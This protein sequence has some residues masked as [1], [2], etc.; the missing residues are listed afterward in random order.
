MLGIGAALS[1]RRGDDFPFVNFFPVVGALG[2]AI[3]ILGLI[4]IWHQYIF[5]AL[6][7]IFAAAL[8][9]SAANYSLPGRVAGFISK[10]PLFSAAFALGLV[11]FS[12]AALSYPVSTDALYFHLGLPKIYAQSGHMFFHPGILFSAGPRT[13]E[14]ISTGFY[15]LG[16]ERGA[17]FFIIL[18]AAI[19]LFAVYSRAGTFCGHGIWAA[20]LLLSV[21]IFVTQLTGSKNDYLLWGLCFFAALK[22]LEFRETR[23]AQALIL[24][25]AAAGMAAGTKAIGLAMFGPPAILILIEIAFGKNRLRHLAYFLVPSVLLAAPW[26]AYSWIVTGNPVFPF[27]DGLF[28]SHETTPLF[29]RFNAYLAVPQIPRT[30]L[31]FIISPIRL[32][33]QPELYDGRLGY[34]LILF[35]ALLIFVARIPS[36]IKISLGISL[37]FYIIWFFG[38][39][40]ARFLLPVGPLLAIAGSYFISSTGMK[41]KTLWLVAVVSLVLALLAPLPG[42]IRDTAPR[43]L[44][45]I[46]NTPRIEYLR[47]FEALDPYQTQSGRTFKPIAYIDC[48]QFINDHTPPGSKIGILTSFQTRADAFYLDR[49]FYYLNPSEQVHF[50][51]T[52]LRGDEDIKA[53]LSELGITH[54]VIDSAVIAEYSPGSAWSDKTGFAVFAGG[55]R[56]LR[57]YGAKSGEQIYRDIRFLVYEL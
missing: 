9:W 10:H 50:D 19:L 39:P 18:V 15:F 17:Q 46:Q 57:E 34:A 8:V 6:T 25:G 28:H 35:P 54:V 41:S 4:D 7:I 53:A 14:M 1:G 36:K 13:M 29:E 33:Y 30:L 37:L 45:V 3:Y 26:Y 5:I 43:A 56:A 55:V 16:L 48:W 42:V 20:L 49:E 31:N 2:M 23:K 12:A 11:W 51:F 52:R 40:I 22:Y 24:S 27:F 32:I 38:F 21:P 44:A 47:D